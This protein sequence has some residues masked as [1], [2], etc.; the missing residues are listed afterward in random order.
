MKLSQLLFIVRA[1]IR[2]ILATI[3]IV[4]AVTMLVSLFLPKTYKA[5]SQV[6]LNYQGTDAVTGLATPTNMMP[7]FVA[8]QI[9]IINSRN[10]ALKVVDAMRLAENEKFKSEFQKKG[11]GMGDIREWLADRLLKNFNALASRESGVI[12]ISFKWDEPKFAAAV[13]NEFATQYQQTT[14]QIKADP[15]DQVGQYFDGQIKSLR[16]SLEAAQG[17]QSQY[18]Q[19]KG[20]VSIDSRVDV[21]SIRLNELSSQLVAVQGQLMEAT[22]RQQQAAG[23]HAAESPDV[24]SNQLIQNVKAALVQA[25][26]RLAQVESMFMPEHSTY[27]RAKAE[28]DRLRS[29]LA[30][31]IRI[32]SNSI[33]NNANVLR[34]REQELSNALQLQKKRVLEL[35]RSRDQLAVLAREVESA[36]RAYDNT[37]NRYSQIKLEGHA[38]QSDVTILSRAVPPTE[39]ASP[40]LMLNFVLSLFLGAMAGLGLG[41]MAEILNRKVRC[42]TDL[43]DALEAPVIGVMEWSVPKPRRLGFISGKPHQLRLN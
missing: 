28:T 14:I 42:A 2:F 21:E 9:G 38:K 10:V 35:N 37:M 24:V 39:P 32:T 29:E 23:T 26:S 18:Q 33:A 34:Q 40:K 17:R 15:L 30:K 13:A 31:N 19:D 3:F 20:I 25:E 5:S 27:K 16:A 7:N 43:M 8:T 1:R 12:I 41:I 22:Y 11:P 6:V 36:Q 4:V